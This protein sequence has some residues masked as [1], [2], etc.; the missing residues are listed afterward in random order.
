MV[1]FLNPPRN[2]VDKKSLTF[3]LFAFAIIGE[4]CDKGTGQNSHP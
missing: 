1:Q 4:Y 2:R 3:F